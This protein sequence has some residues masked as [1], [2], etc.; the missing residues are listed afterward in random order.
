MEETQL[1]LSAEDF[2]LMNELKSFSEVYHGVGEEYREVEHIVRISAD[3]LRS[4]IPAYI[5]GTLIPIMF[6][7]LVK[8]NTEI[9]SI[10]KQK[11]IATQ[12][13]LRAARAWGKHT[14][15]LSLKCLYLLMTDYYP[16]LEY[17][18]LKNTSKKKCGVLKEFRE[19]FVAGFNPVWG[20]FGE[21]HYEESK[22][23][24]VSF[25]DLVGKKVFFIKSDRREHDNVLSFNVNKVIGFSDNGGIQVRFASEYYDK[26]NVVKSQFW[27]GH[28]ERGV[29]Y[30]HDFTYV[31]FDTSSL[32]HMVDFR[33]LMPNVS[34]VLG[35]I[36]GYHEVLDG[37]VKEW[38]N[39]FKMKLAAY[40]VLAKL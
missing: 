9:L 40:T 14:T 27:S 33:S 18:F 3:N 22:R 16:T 5:G 21:Y 23:S 7:N 37:E 34:S 26:D 15:F 31:M 2:N 17:W 13:G 24:P 38:F 35:K 10:D 1:N 39:A 36:R 29:G 32:I 12:N 19:A 6:S 4:Q 25:E 11:V 20:E 28:Y 8:K 30:K